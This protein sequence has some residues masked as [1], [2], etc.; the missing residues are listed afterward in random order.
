M[1]LLCVTLIKLLN[2]NKNEIGVAVPL[3]ESEIALISLERNVC[4]Y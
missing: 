3:V 1:I 2:F 4:F